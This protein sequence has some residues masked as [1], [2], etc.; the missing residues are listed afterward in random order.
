MHWLV[1]VIVGHLLSAVSFVLDKVLLTK[2]IQNTFAF[3]FF[4]GLLSGSI[5][6]LIP[7]EFA[8]FE[9][10]S[11]GMIVLNL[12]VGALFILALLFFFFALKGGEASRVTP[13]IGGLIPVLTLVFEVL[14]LNGSFTTI[15]LAAFAIL[16][17]GTIVITI[18]PDNADAKT[19]EKQG[20]RAWMYGGA[21]A[22]AFALSFGLTAIAFESQPFWSAFIWTRFGSVAVVLVFL[23]WK[24]NRV[25]IRESLSLFKEAAGWIYLLAQSFGAGGYIFINYAISLASVSLVNA[26]QG[27]QYAIL[28]LMAIL[29]SV[30]NPSLLGESMSKRSLS[31]KIVGVVIIS[32]G[33]YLVTQTSLSIA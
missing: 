25:A 27:V 3:T 10:P 17:I 31:I 4:I 30:V 23:F 29:G 32:I 8:Q 9:V 5:A 21:A 1:A 15:Q 33:L 26:L 28:L 2:S 7:F 18:D 6:I 13:F 24:S 12:A 14:F 20:L 22:L 11:A 16:V 19:K